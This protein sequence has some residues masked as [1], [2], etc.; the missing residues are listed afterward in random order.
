MNHV[1]DIK[2]H[3][4]CGNKLMSYRLNR[5]DGELLIDL[6]DGIIDNTTT[7]ITLIGRNL[8]RFWR[9]F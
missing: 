7:D 3:Y 2:L 4:L 1:H 9:I 6:T 8:Q 5:T